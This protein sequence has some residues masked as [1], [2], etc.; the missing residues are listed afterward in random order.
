MDGKGSRFP[1]SPPVPTR[2]PRH[3]GSP[4]TALWFAITGF[5]FID[6]TARV[7]K[8]TRK[9][10]GVVLVLALL[11]PFTLAALDSVQVELREPENFTDFK[12]SDMGSG[13]EVAELV[14]EWT[15]F[16]GEEAKKR[17]S[18][19]GTLSITFTDIDMAGDFEPWRSVD[20]PDIRYVRSIYPPRLRFEYCLT[21]ADG[22]EIDSGEEYLRDLNFELG[23][24]PGYER[25]LLFYEKSLLRNW[26]IGCNSRLEKR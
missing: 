22:K 6:S 3:F 1:C 7:M 10:V 18:Y 11:L 20:N 21:D 5:V 9:A 14:D 17:I 16:V 2:G 4:D 15:S 8:T 13:K 26:L 19:P 23:R 25:E 12:Q 24:T